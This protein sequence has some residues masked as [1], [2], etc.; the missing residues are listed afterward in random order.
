M[1][2]KKEGL[3]ESSL[4]SLLNCSWKQSAIGHLKGRYRKISP[5]QTPNLLPVS[6][7]DHSKVNFR[8]PG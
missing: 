4:Y 5:K 1:V 8:L 2:G 6:E 3:E 7:D